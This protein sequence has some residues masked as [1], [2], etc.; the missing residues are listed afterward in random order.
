MNRP[1]PSRTMSLGGRTRRLGTSTLAVAPPA[2]SPISGPIDPRGGPGSASVRRGA[3]EL[4][5]DSTGPATD[6]ARDEA[7]GALPA[8]APP[9]R[10]S[11]P[12]SAFPGTTGVV[13]FP[14]PDSPVPLPD[15]GFDRIAG[16]RA[17]AA[18]ANPPEPIPALEPVPMPIPGDRPIS[19]PPAPPSPGSPAAW[20]RGTAAI[21]S[22]SGP[23]SP[24]RCSRFPGMELSPGSSAAATSPPTPPRSTTIGL[25]RMMGEGGRPVPVP[26]VSRDI[27]MRLG[28]GTRGDP[29]SVMPGVAGN[30]L[31]SDSASPLPRSGTIRSGAPRP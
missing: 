5:P 24:A 16:A 18:G 26:A 9:A 15:P 29:R 25:R 14:I 6:E 17:G 8:R 30:V 7:P 22:I 19:V 20:R 23:E 4:A 31:D 27:S 10:G 28:A 12:P 21:D 13:D 2:G 1:V 3:A 11:S